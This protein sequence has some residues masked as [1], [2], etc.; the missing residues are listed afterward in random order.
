MSEEKDEYFYRD[1]N[2]VPPKRVHK[3]LVIEVSWSW[4]FFWGSM[5]GSGTAL[6]AMGILNWLH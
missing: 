3:R 5:C 2:P 6:I 4:E 1:Y